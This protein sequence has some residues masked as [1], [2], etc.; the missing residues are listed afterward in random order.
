MELGKRIVMRRAIDTDVI[1]PYFFERLQIV[2]ND[3]AARAH[4]GH[5]AHLAWFQPAALN[6]GES[7]IAEAKRQIRHVFHSGSDV[8]IPLTIH[9]QRQLVQNMENDGDVVRRQIPDDIDIL[10]E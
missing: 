5:L 1:D 2:V 6:C 10:L 8:C 4:D 9:G 7:F 3:H